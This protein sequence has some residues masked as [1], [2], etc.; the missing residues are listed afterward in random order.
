MDLETRLLRAAL[1]TYAQG[2]LLTGLLARERLLGQLE[3]ISMA[4]QM[5][6]EGG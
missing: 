6:R 3:G 1:S 2:Q 4:L 5:V